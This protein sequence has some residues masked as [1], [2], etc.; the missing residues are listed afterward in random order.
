MA[1]SDMIG[2]PRWSGWGPLLK[3][4]LLR[5]LRTLGTLHVEG[6]RA[7]PDK[8]SLEAVPVYPIRVICVDGLMNRANCRPFLTLV[9]EEGERGDRSGAGL[10]SRIGAVDDRVRGRRQR[11]GVGYE[12]AMM[13]RLRLRHCNEPRMDMIV[14]RMQFRSFGGPDIASSRWFRCGKETYGHGCLVGSSLRK[15]RS[16][17]VVWRKGN[18]VEVNLHPRCRGRD[19][20]K[21]SPYSLSVGVRLHC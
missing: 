1:G 20:V 7:G 6:E 10:W 12:W 13:P 9:Q 5:T 8:H 16:L 21:T 15:R 11:E 3:R 2:H 19:R 17:C 18:L 4:C 14:A